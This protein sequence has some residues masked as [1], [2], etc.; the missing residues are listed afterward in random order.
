MKKILLLLVLAAVLP[1]S[2]Q[3]I[4]LKKGPPIDV[5]DM[6]SK[7]QYGILVNAGKDK[8]TGEKIAGILQ[9]QRLE[10]AVAYMTGRKNV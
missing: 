10:T 3:K 6:I 5:K 1:L 7:D 4:M 2:A 9:A 8:E